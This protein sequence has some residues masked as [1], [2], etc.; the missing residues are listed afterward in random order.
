MKTPNDLRCELALRRLH[1]SINRAA[2]QHSRAIAL[3]FA[4]ARM[5]LGL[6]SREQVARDVALRTYMG[7]GKPCAASGCN[8]PQGDCLGLGMGC[9]A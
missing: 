9:M 5:M 7:Q 3:R 6:P 2:G 1:S 8:Y 4:A